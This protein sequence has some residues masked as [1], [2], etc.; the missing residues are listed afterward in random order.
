MLI[1]MSRRAR[2]AGAFGPGLVLILGI[3]VSLAVSGYWS[4]ALDERAQTRFDERVA[5]ARHALEAEVQRYEDALAVTRG[6]FQV[7]DT[8]GRSEFH[9]F[10]QSLSVGDRYP[11]LLALSYV[12][13]VRG[14]DL[15]AF[16]ARER[17]EVPGFQVV[18]TGERPLS[19]VMTYV[20]PAIANEPLIGFDAFTDTERKAGL[21]RA[22]DGDRA[23]LTPTLEGSGGMLARTQLALPVYRN[24]RFLGWMTADLQPQGLANVALGSS[25]ALRIE[26]LDESYRGQIEKIAVSGGLERTSEGVRTRLVSVDVE[27]RAWTLRISAPRL[28][29]LSGGELPPVFV[30][31]LGAVGSLLGF[32]FLW[33][34]T[35]SRIKA[36]R[37]VDERTLELRQ[38]EAKARAVLEMAAEAIIT[39]DESGRVLSFNP[40]AEE[41]F[42]YRS[43]EVLGRNLTA[44]MPSPYVEEHDDYMRRYIETGER[45][46]IGVGREVEGRRKDGSV[47]PMDITVSEVP[48]E[49]GRIFTGFARDIT[50]RKTFEEFL[51]HEASH[52]P[53]TGLPNRRMFEEV[54]GKAIARSGRSGAP[55][56]V[57]FVDLDGFK[58][59]N[60]TMGHAAG[61][62]V[63]TATARRLAAA[64]RPGDVVARLGGDEFAV[65]CEDVGSGGNASN[66]AER[67]V[68]AM[69]V[70]FPVGGRGA[71]I[72]ASVGVALSFDGVEE[73]R[74][75]VH[76]ADEAMYVAKEQGKARFVVAGAGVELH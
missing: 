15:K 11:A 49:E 56:A 63:L 67:I 64:V 32:G 44:L 69:G 18:P 26:I 31:L 16:V 22:R 72:S 76:R 36:L 10:E 34:L 73:P 29:G 37:L 42:G 27:D 60:D 28:F 58:G 20:E 5:A 12:V 6:F 51:T 46:I 19:Y 24:G 21:E 48:T 47:F 13:P 65:L 7:D 40:A 55:L 8:V 57:L 17:R 23:T 50:M 52:D 43:D 45:R 59:V 41:L 71:E 53:L 68:R 1:G 14:D 74:A 38:S 2:L 62:R 33:A 61:D 30:F 3:V 35:H 54:L 9:E 4:R 25:E 70:P 39:A 75:L 66:I